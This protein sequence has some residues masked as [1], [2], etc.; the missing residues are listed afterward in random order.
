MRLKRLSNKEIR[1]LNKDNSFLR[2]N[3]S[4]NKGEELYIVSDKSY[5]DMIIKDRK[6]I[7]FKDEKDEWIPSLYLIANNKNAYE[8]LPKVAVNDG[9]VKFILNGA[10]IMRPGIVD[11]TDFSKDD[12]V[13]VLN[14]NKGI[15]AVGSAV[16]SS[17]DMRSLSKGVVVNNL[18]HVN[19]NIFKFTR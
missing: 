1:E 19:D 10:N 8:V 12:V 7:L 14:K 18:H 6:A 11:W 16:I 5:P 17:E 13:L 2:L 15:L 3:I 9:A 4:F